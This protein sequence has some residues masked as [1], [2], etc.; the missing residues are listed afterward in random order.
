M[1]R[2]RFLPSLQ[3]LVRTAD[4][5]APATEVLPVVDDAYAARVLDLAIRIGETMLVAGAPA[6][7]VTLT[8]VRIC[9]VYGLEPVHVDVTYNAITVGHHRPGADRPFT[10]LR[11]VRAAAPDHARLQ[12]LQ[13]L[14]AEVA[15]G[16]PLDAAVARFRTVRRTPFRYSAPVV[17]AAQA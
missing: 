10:L 7:D 2:R 12:R 16:L 17:V 13:S 9:G 4:P 11:V 14:V 1:A 5:S 15:D 6:N 3:A 8:I